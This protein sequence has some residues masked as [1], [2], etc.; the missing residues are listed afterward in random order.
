MY[1]PLVRCETESSLQLLW[2]R[3]MMRE[4][5]IVL[6]TGVDYADLVAHACAGTLAW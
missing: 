3:H 6:A 5:I 2:Q 4:C 1:C